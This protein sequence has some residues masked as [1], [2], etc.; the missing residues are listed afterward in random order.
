M[1]MYMK[2]HWDIVST[3]IG[4]NVTKKKEIFYNAMISVELDK[5]VLLH[6]YTM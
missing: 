4:I 5:G 3:L 6:Y 1:K 2:T